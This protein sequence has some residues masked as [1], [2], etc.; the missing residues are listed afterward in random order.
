MSSIPKI[1]RS[2]FIALTVCCAAGWVSGG[3]AKKADTNVVAESR[4][5]TQAEA[6]KQIATVQNDKS[7]PE[8]A[9]PSIIGGIQSRVGK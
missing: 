8:T 4:K 6:D 5:F 1:R 7:I 9:K 2:L 3:C